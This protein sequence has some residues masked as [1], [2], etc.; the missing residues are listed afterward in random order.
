MK[1]KLTKGFSYLSLSVGFMFNPRDNRTVIGSFCKKYFEI[2]ILSFF[3]F[4]K[5]PTTVAVTVTLPLLLSK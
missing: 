4:D 3:R 2:K 5:N 1:N